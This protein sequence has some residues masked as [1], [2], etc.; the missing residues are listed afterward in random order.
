MK[1]LILITATLIISQTTFAQW[2]RAIGI[3]DRFVYS[4]RKIDNYLFAATDSGVYRS[5]DGINWQMRINGM[6]TNELNTREF[7][8]NGIILYAASMAG[9]YVSTDYGNNWQLTS[10]PHPNNPAISVFAINNIIL[11][12]TTGGGLYSSSDSGA[13]WTPITG[14]HFWKYAM[15][16][17]KL[18]AST[19]Q[20]VSVSLDTGN[21][22]Q[23]TNFNVFAYDL[24]NVNDTL[25]VTAFSNGIA[26]TP[27]GTINWSYVN[28]LQ[29]NYA[30]EFATKADTIF[31]CS[32]DS[33]YYFKNRNV[34]AERLSLNRLNVFPDNKLSTIEISNNLLI[35]GTENSNTLLGKGV[36][37]CP[38]SQIV[39]V[40]DNE[41]NVNKFH[42]NQ[43]YPNPFNLTTTIR[44][45]IPHAEYVILK[46][47]DILGREIVTLMN[48]ELSA[49]EHTIV[50]YA[51][52]LASGIYFYRLN[53]ATSSLVKSMEIMK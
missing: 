11:A 51:K 10:Y 38:L 33:I 48:D 24:L 53:T 35:V 5:T 37:Y 8:K 12:S 14:D 18:F 17:R 4:I 13:T 23:S 30:F 21:T 47:Y 49:G 42:L 20:D 46:V 41:N 22:W 52:D 39:T 9:L 36:W 15:I 43:N 34:R 26:Q 45:S 3:G 40:D 16:N 6:D 50:F 19:W 44:F 29:I 7:Y 25:L 27:S 1:K 31:V 32:A 28:P 2:N